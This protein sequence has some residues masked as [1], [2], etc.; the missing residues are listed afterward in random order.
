M[1]A[2]QYKIFRKYVLLFSNCLVDRLAGG[3][4]WILIGNLQRWKEAK[5]LH[6]LSAA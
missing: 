2:P 1:S 4:I 6:I 5:K 3:R